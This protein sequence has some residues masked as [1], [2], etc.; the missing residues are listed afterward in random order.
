MRDPEHYIPVTRPSSPTKLNVTHVR[1]SAS[2]W[3]GRGIRVGLVLAER[4]PIFTS[5]LLGRGNVHINYEPATRL[6]QK[7]VEKAQERA[8]AE[9]QAGAGPVWDALQKVLIESGLTLVT[10]DAPVS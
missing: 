6:N 4:G 5:L 8:L 1:V 9:I 3:K 7:N 10:N 2:Y